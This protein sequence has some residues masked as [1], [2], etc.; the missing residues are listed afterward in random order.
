MNGDAEVI[1]ASR[2]RP[3]LICPA[4]VKDKAAVRLK[5]PV[6]DSGKLGK[7]VNVFVLFPV[8]VL[9]LSLEGEGRACHHQIDAV[10]GELRQELSGIPAICLSPMGEIGRGD[11]EVAEKFTIHAD[12]NLICYL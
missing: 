4:Q 2:W 1:E 9:F 11:G 7:P 8:S 6:N 5:Y 10:V 12:S 3:L